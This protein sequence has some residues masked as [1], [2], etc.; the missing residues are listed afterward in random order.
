MGL[1]V[2]DDVAELC[3]DG[4]GICDSRLRSKF[5]FAFLSDMT[6]LHDTMLAYDTSL[7]ILQENRRSRLISLNCEVTDKL[8]LKM[9]KIP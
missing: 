3:S 9:V 4:L 6:N 7:S 5:I 1:V 2:C 8:D